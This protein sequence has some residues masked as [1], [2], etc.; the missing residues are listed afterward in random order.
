MAL[1]IIDLESIENDISERRELV[2]KFA[3]HQV[4]PTVLPGWWE[5]YYGP[6][7]IWAIISAFMLFTGMLSIPAGWLVYG[8]VMTIPTL[9][10]KDIRKQRHQD[11]R[12]TGSFATAA[13]EFKKQSDE[14]IADI[15]RFNDAVRA[16]EYLAPD[17]RGDAE[18]GL[19]MERHDLRCRERLLLADFHQ[20][21]A[22]CIAELERRQLWS[23][24]DRLS[25]VRQKRIGA[26]AAAA[27]DNSWATLGPSRLKS[28]LNE[29]RALKSEAPA[30]P[31][32]L[33]TDDK[34]A[35]LEETF[36]HEFPK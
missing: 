2:K 36:G 28:H 34:F 6:L 21:F 8:V 14:L 16:L 15:R 25:S 23:R 19:S 30:L 33:D 10:A 24:A 22:P 18:R 3:E 17:F 27:W 9:V 35:A 13:E 20:A 31:D 1:S 32:P 29:I 5:T 7:G 11:R 4:A 12:L 26:L